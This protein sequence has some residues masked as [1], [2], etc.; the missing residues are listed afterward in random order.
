MTKGDFMR[1]V[2]TEDELR[3]IDP[4]LPAEIYNQKGFNSWCHVMNYNEPTPFGKLDNMFEVA[5][6]RNIEVPFPVGTEEMT[7]ICNIQA[8][9]EIIEHRPTPLWFLR[10]KTLEQLREEQE[11]LIPLYNKAIAWRYEE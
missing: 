10:D 11:R 2:Y 9:N 6:Q 1:L 8:M 3:N 7:V 4:S 5:D